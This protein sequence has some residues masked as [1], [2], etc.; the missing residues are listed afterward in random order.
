MTNEWTRRSWLAAGAMAPWWKAAGT[1]TET[2]WRLWYREPA[3]RWID[4]LPVGNGRLGAMVHGGVGFEVLQLNEDSLWAG[5]PYPQ[6]GSRFREALPKVRA[7]LQAGSYAEA[8]TLASKT[9]V[10]EWGKWF[11]AHQTLGELVIETGHAGATDYVR[12]L[13][14]E[15]GIARV[16]YRARGSAWERTVFASRKQQ[17]VV[18]RFT[19]TAPVHLRITARREQAQVEVNDRGLRWWGQA[20]EGGVRW[21]AWTEV[22]LRGGAW[23]LDGG[24]LE[25]GGA[26]EVVLVT[27]A[28]T[29]Y[30]GRPEPDPIRRPEVNYT[31]WLEEHRAA[32]AAQFGRVTLDLGGTEHAARPTD[33]RLS[34]VQAGAEDRHL[35]A[36]YFQFGRYLLMSSSQPGSL[37]ANLQG[38]WNH[39]LNPPWE[40]DYHLNINIPMNYWPAEVTN[41]SECHEPLFDFAEKLLEPGARVARDFYGMRGSVVH[42]TTNV[43]GYAEPGHGLIFG[44]WQDGLAW[45]ARHFWERWLF[46]GDA[47]FLRRRAWP[48]LQAAARFQADFLTDDKA[49]RLVPGPAASPENT[50]LTASGGR[51]WITMGCAASVQAV[52]DLFGMAIEAARLLGV[53]PEFARELQQK[54]ARMGPPIELGKHGQVKEWQE[55]FDEAEPGHRHVSHLYSLHPAAD[56]DVR[57]TPE[58]ARACRVT[59]ERRLAAGSGQTGWS[60]AWM[61]SFFARLEDGAKAHEILYKLLRQSTEPNLFDTH[62]ARGGPVFQIDGNFGGCAG[63]AEMLLQSHAGEIHLLPALPPAWSEGRVKGLRA[64]GGYEVE[65]EWRAG[66]LLRAAVSASRKGTAVVRHGTRVEERTHEAGERFEIRGGAAG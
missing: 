13:R 20:P 11:G 53:E 38:L 16:R 6:D 39:R 31:E 3:A 51:G 2:A 46:S 21:Q 8:N 1:E 28:W 61:V 44:L 34:A 41:L 24:W 42:Y 40:C 64:R 12:E 30:G 58:W 36:L 52:R 32:H 49:G 9:L 60:A 7:L 37:P 35:A 4:A 45:L 29:N 27:R 56:V 57:R 26:E 65:M 33:E 43:W 23:R 19:G 17:A 55:D 62:P 63:I 14:I 5:R 48:V 10:G 22:Q 50:Y 47:E 25:I 66:R 59:L 18:A 54:L 15:D